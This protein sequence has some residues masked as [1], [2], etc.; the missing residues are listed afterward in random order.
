M[1]T[2]TEIPRLALG[3]GAWRVLEMDVLKMLFADD[4]P[5]ISVALPEQGLV[6]PDDGPKEVA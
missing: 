2:P 5:H 3:A 4:P 1:P 6:H